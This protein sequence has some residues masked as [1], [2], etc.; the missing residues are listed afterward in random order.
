VTRQSLQVGRGTFSAHAEAHEARPARMNRSCAAVL[1]LEFLGEEARMEFLKRTTV[2]LAAVATI[3]VGTAQANL[4]LVGPVTLGGTGLGAVNTVLTLSSFGSS[5]T[6]QGCVGTASGTD[7]IGSTASG[8]CV[9]GTSTDV[10]TGASQT[11]TRTLSEAG[12]TSGTNFAILFNAAEPGNASGISMES[13]SATFYGANGS[14]FTAN[15][16]A[17]PTDFTST[18][19]GT[20]TTGFEFTLNAA[21]AA[22][23]QSLITANGGASGVRVGLSTGLGATDAATGGNETFFVFNSATTPTLTPEPSTTALLATGLVGLVGFVR[24]RRA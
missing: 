19:S 24:R 6:E 5:T 11:Q 3:G 17:A 7:F 9:S 10:K 1:G 23:L 16:A 8:A 15:Y 20:G 2:A 13:L 22:S 14:T 4:V 21:E 18:Q 12:V